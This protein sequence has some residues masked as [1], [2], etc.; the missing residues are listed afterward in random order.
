MCIRD[1]LSGAPWWEGLQK[2]MKDV[3]Q[4]FKLRR[5]REAIAHGV[6]GD[7]YIS[8]ED[9][10][11]MAEWQKAHEEDEKLKEIAFINELQAR[12]ARVEQLAHSREFNRTKDRLK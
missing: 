7:P 12:N 11:R 2:D 4:Y 1:T 9:A 10:E 5:N 3:S 8:A 6:R